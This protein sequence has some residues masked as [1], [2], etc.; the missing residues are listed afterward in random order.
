MRSFPLSSF[1][2]LALNLWTVSSFSL[3]PNQGTFRKRSTALEVIFSS[4]AGGAELPD[5][6]ENQRRLAEFQDLEP[7]EES[8]ARRARME[9]DLMNR[10]QFVQHGNDLWLLRKLMQNLSSKLV[11]AINGDSREKENDIREKLL[12]IEKRDPDLMYDV[13]LEQMQLAKHEG[14]TSDAELHSM[15]AIAARSCMPHF[16]LEGLWVGK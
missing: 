13:E 1:V 6:Q 8:A 10:E 4:D 11:V 3:P 5:E 9:R 2:I 7:L 14:R 16:N 12:E 15:K